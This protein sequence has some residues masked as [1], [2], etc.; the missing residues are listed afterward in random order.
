[1]RADSLSSGLILYLPGTGVE[2]EQLQ[3]LLAAPETAADRTSLT[4]IGLEALRAARPGQ[5]DRPNISA[6][7]ILPAEIAIVATVTVP[8]D[9]PQH[10]RAAAPN[11]LEESMASDPEQLHLAYGERSIAGEVALVALDRNEFAK[12][13]AAIEHSGLQCDAVLIDALLLRHE[14]GALTLVLD[15]ERALLRWGECS[16]G[17]IEIIGLMPLLQAILQTAPIVRIELS[18]TGM[19]GTHVAGFLQHQLPELLNE[20]PLTINRHTFDGSLLE[21]LVAQGAQLATSPIDLRQG[22][23]QAPQ[24]SNATWRRWRPVAYVAVGLLVA[25][26]ILNLVAGAV[27]Q[28]RAQNTHAEAEALYRELFPND[29]RLVNLQ[30]QLQS[31]LGSL[32]G[33]DRRT[34]LELFGALAREIQKAPGTPPIQ[35]RAMTYDVTSGALLVDL[36]IADVQALDDLQK[37]LSVDRLRAKVLSAAAAEEGGIT[38]RLSLSGG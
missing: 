16:A 38:G 5:A 24:R 32:A 23:F 27:L 22:E 14:P 30:Q 36:T 13:L 7:L 11:L 29:R 31:Q 34:F 17:A 9:K 33:S 10:I 12:Q 35:L 19:P 25:Q 21:L 37:Q 3:W 2:S 8:S 6:T 18:T 15:G 1:M 20:H 28:H 26:L 4:G